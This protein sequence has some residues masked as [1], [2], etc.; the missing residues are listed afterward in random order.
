MPEFYTILA[1]KIS[2]IPEF[3]YN[4]FRKIDKIPEFYMILPE[5]ARILRNNCWKKIFSRLLGGDVP[6][7]P[8]SHAYG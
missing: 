7:A 1:R 4:I 3:F 2:K 8:V 5:N 6:H